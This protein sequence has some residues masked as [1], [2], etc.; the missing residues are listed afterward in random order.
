MAMMPYNQHVA[1][2]RAGVPSAAGSTVL[3]TPFLP[4]PTSL[5]E[6]AWPHTGVPTTGRVPLYFYRTPNGVLYDSR[7]VPPLLRGTHLT[8]CM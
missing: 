3:G 4:A 7:S 8:A 5:H 1:G 6:T 2:L